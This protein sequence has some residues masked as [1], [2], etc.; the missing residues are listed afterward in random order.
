A[1]TVDGTVVQRLLYSDDLRPAGEVD[2]NGDV[3]ARYV[4]ASRS[5]VPDLIIRGDTT[6]R[7]VTDHLGSPRFVVNTSSG[8]V[9]QAVTYDEFGSVLTDTNPGFQPFGFGGGLYDVDTGLVRFG[10]RDYD[11]EI[12]RWTAKDPILFEGGD[13]NLYAYVLNDP[14]NLIDPSGLLFGG[15]I[16]AGEAYGDAAL[17]T[18]ADIL[19]DPDAAWY[20]KAGA[21]VGGFFSALWTPCTS[22]STFAV[23]STA[24]GGAGGLRAAGSKVAGKEFSHWI[25]DRALKRTGSKWLRNKFGMSPFNGNYVPIERHSLHDP[26]RMLK[27]MTKAD[28]WPPVVRQLDRVPRLYY[29]TAVGAGLGAAAIV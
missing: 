18:Y 22:D 3:I 7:I 26:W 5:N 14:I 28:K 1:K 21:A 19:T 15:T 12:G 27:G 2:A 8:D 11:A 29:G 4:Y 25:P 6:F 17:A 9:V 13:A 24:A 16:N 23:L 20:E 10:A